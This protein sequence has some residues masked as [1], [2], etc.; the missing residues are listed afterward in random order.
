M[1]RSFVDLGRVHFVG[2]G[3]T[4]MSGIAEVLLD[5][6][7]EVSGSDV[8]RSEATARLEDLGATIAFGHQAANVHGADLVEPSG[9]VVV[10]HQ[11]SLLRV[12]RS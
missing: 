7:L 11:G 1:F 8:A 10:G 4:G 3:G 12:S 9:R 6:E 5:Y 2:I